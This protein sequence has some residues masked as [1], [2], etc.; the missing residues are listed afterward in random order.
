VDNAGTEAAGQISRASAEF[1]KAFA[2]Q[3]LPSIREA[4]RLMLEELNPG[5]VPS[6]VQAAFG[7]ARAKLGTEFEADKARSL[8][9]LKQAALQS[10]LDFQPAAISEAAGQITRS[11]DREQGARMR[12]LNFEEANIGLNQTNRMIANILKTG[13]STAQGA[14]GFGGNAL[15]SANLLSQIN[16]QQSQQNATYGSMIG[17]IVGGIGGSFFGP[18]GTMVGMGVGSGVGGAI[19]G[20]W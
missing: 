15:N 11:I 12:A 3:A 16:Q 7:E 13:S 20:L 2:D 8:A 18:G 9:S 1:Q 5:G 14:I 6:S 17:S 19:G 10:G 4:A